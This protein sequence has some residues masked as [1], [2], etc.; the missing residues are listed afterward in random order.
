[1]GDL[2]FLKI[3]EMQLFQP[4]N[5]WLIEVVIRQSKNYLHVFPAIFPI[6]NFSDTTAAT[7]LSGGFQKVLQSRQC[8][9]WETKKATIA[10]QLLLVI[11]EV[12]VYEV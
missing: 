7:Y 3:D 9:S 8:T 2:T 12:L 5:N 11:G 4:K 1:M 10:T 6:E